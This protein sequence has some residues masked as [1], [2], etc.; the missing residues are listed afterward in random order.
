MLEQPPFREQLGRGQE[1]FLRL[2]RALTRLSDDQ[3]AV[4]E[5][6]LLHGLTVAE[7]CELT[8]LSKG[9]LAAHLFQG[10]KTLRALLDE[11]GNPSVGNR[12]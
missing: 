5:M 1:E 6:K 10:M 8:S 2:T 3:R 11:P 9:S 7:I 4:L 12:G